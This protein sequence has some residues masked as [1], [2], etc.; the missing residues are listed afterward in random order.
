MT[1]NIASRGPG[2]HTGAAAITPDQAEAAARLL[3][4]HRESGRSIEALPAHLRPGDAASGHA[5]QALLP[6]VTGRAVVGWKIAA[7]STAG[8]AHIGV[9]GPL[10]GRV[11]AGQVLADGD[12]LSLAGNL[13]RVAEPEFAFRFGQAL[14][15]RT[16]PY[17]VDEVLDAVDA[18]LP[19]IEEPDSRFTDFARAG[20]AQL[21]ADDACA[22]RF[23]IGSAERVDWRALDLCTHRVSARVLGA[24]GAVRIAREGDGSVVL[25]DPR[26][27]LTWLV[28]EASTLGVALE[29]GQWVSTGTC[30]VPLPVQPGDRVEVDYGVLGRVSARFT[31]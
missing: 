3:W 2:A 11:L 14:A 6:S 13:M 8:Q 24:D 22:R 29:P 9:S 12:A 26:V 23:V 1:S 19:S 17:T 28:N 20:E 16:T 31:A 25:G 18:L 10:A 21:I 15:P 27:A 30:M 7:T 5:I 4:S